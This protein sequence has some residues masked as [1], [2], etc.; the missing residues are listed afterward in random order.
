MLNSIYG[1]ICM[2]L[3]PKPQGKQFGFMPSELTNPLVAA[4]CTGLVRAVLGEQIYHTHNQGGRVVSVTTDGFITDLNPHDYGILSPT[5]AYGRLFA[6][7]RTLL[8]HEGEHIMETKGST[9]GLASW[10]VRGQLGSAETAPIKAM[11][12]YQSWRYEQLE[13]WE[14]IVDKME[15]GLRQDIRP[16]IEFSHAS[17]RTGGDILKHGGHVTHVSRR[18]RL[19]LTYDERRCIVN[20]K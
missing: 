6:S 3:N 16:E 7:T 4:Y 14:Q 2:G 10:T 8:G 1:Q 5:G 9:C 20:E 11:T 17:V 12:G 13:L 19:S 18:R 15:R